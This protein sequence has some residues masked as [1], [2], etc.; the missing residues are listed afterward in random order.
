VVVRGTTAQFCKVVAKDARRTGQ[1]R[2]VA[3]AVCRRRVCLGVASRWC[4]GVATRGHEVGCRGY[5]RHSTLGLRVIK[6][7]KSYPRHRRAQFSHLWAN[8]Q[9]YRQTI[10]DNDRTV[11]PYVVQIWSRTLYVSSTGV[12][13]G[14]ED[15]GFG[16]RVQG[17]GFRVQGS[18]VPPSVSNIRDWR[19][20]G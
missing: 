19:G 7:E 15:C 3:E 12:P 18:G 5:P 13:G 6:R 17:S 11:R 14:V 4:V 16:F 10:P 8:A 2:G 9:Q 20:F 1:D